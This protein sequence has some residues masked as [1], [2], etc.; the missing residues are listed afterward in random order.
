MVFCL[1][2]GSI[3]MDGGGDYAMRIWFGLLG[4]EVLGA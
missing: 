3:L 1:L 2:A 4:L